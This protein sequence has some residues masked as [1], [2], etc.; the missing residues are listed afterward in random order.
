MAI[1]GAGPSGQDICGELASVAN[2]VFFI[3]RRAT[4]KGMPKNV[5]QMY[6]E[7]IGF[8]SKAVTI[9]IDGNAPIDIEIDAVI[10]ATG[11][12]FNLKYLDSKTC[13]L[14]VNDQTISGLYRHLINIEHPTMALMSVLIRVLPF[15]LFHQ[16][17][18]FFVKHILGEVQLPSKEVMI[19]R[20][21]K[22]FEQ[23]QAMGFRQQDRHLTDFDLHEQYHK[24][25][26]KEGQLKPLEPVILKFYRY[27]G[28]VR[29]NNIHTYKKKNYR[30]VSSEDFEETF[31]E[32]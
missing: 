16:Q 21:E 12:Q 17:M 32:N 2:Q 27:L 19:A 25:L 18:L 6:G 1:I 20:T 26:V 23:R 29:S 5:Q 15:P 9:S 7:V 13:G 30:I 28:V 3:N 8:K 14:H 22:E 4:F 10:F 31:E 11:Y 24:E